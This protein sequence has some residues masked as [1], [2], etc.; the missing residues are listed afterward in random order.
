MENELTS[1]PAPF[2]YIYGLEGVILFPNEHWIIVILHPPL[3]GPGVYTITAV[4]VAGAIGY[5]YIKWKVSLI[6]LVYGWKCTDHQC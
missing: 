5:A 4:V 2:H 1:P 3:V 6:L